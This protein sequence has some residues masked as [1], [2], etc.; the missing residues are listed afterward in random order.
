VAVV[1]Q[2][3]KTAR[4]AW[5]MLRSGESYRV[6][7]GGYAAAATRTRQ[8]AQGSN[9]TMVGTWVGTLVALPALLACK[10]AAANL[11]QFY[12]RIIMPTNN[13]EQKLLSATCF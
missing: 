13:P 9:G 10:H 6:A 12:F 1:A 5:A 7:G 8:G 2:A 4:I 3:A 11:R